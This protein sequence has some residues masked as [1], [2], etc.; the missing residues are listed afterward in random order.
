MGHG[1]QYKDIARGL[2]TAGFFLEEYSPYDASSVL[3]SRKDWN[4]IAAKTI[5][6]QLNKKITPWE[7]WWSSGA[8]KI[9]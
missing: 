3:V 9:H 6:N 2:R 7:M 1:T 8:L 5:L 4:V